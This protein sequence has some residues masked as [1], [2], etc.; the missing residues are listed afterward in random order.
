M[1]GTGGWTREAT[2]ERKRRV[3][4]L[5]RQGLSAQVIADMLG[6]NERTVVRDR[7]DE[8]VAQLWCGRNAMTAEELERAEELL[9]D[10]C[11]M[12]E[13]A[14]TLGRH[15]MT[16]RHHFPGRSWDPQQ[17]AEYATLMRLR[18]RWENSGSL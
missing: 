3:V 15:D 8:G 9:D 12:A 2:R 18:R 17:T 1:P 4:E 6:V 7:V 5:T 10:G 14:R 11:S 13:V 16:L